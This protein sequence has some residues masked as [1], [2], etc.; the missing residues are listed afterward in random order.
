MGRA[1][2]PAAL[3]YPPSTRA[4][5]ELEMAGQVEVEIAGQVEL[6]MAEQVEVEMRPAGGTADVSSSRTWAGRTAQ[7]AAADATLEDLL[8]E[9][10]I[11]STGGVYA[12]G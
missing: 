8:A 7:R 4:Q 5:V 12:L 6:E 3:R 1:A 2:A 10:V 9:S 11:T